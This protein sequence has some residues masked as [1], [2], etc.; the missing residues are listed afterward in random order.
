MKYCFNCNRITPG[1]PLFCNSC[2]RSYN[3]KLC[4]RRHK[5][6]RSAEACS[7]CGSRDLSTPQPKVP[8]WVPFVEAA[9]SIL[10]G[11]VLAVVSLCGFVLVMVALIHSPQ[12]LSALVFL[13]IALGILWWIWS[14]LPSWFRTAIYKML[15]R[16][17]EGG[18]K[19]SEDA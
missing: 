13:S 8:I 6:P 14:E 18:G 4:P 16:R 9:L 3:V 11:F 5:N 19:R 2:G 7:Q 10:P 17:R 12:F 15:K 1:E